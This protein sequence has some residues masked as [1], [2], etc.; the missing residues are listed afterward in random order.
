MNHDV[1]G[2]AEFEEYILNNHIPLNGWECKEYTQCIRST[3]TNYAFKVCV[4]LWYY[5][6]KMSMFEKLKYAV[7][8]PRGKRFR[9][10]TAT[11]L[12]PSDE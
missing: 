11:T 9:R 3:S 2:R 6:E 5:L 1:I 10:A 4:I 7:V 12:D 8:H